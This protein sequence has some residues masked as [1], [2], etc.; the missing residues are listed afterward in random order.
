LRQ[1]ITTAL[2]N[3]IKDYPGGY[4]IFKELIQNSDDSKATEMHFV[5]DYVSLILL[6]SHKLLVRNL[7][8]EK[9]CRFERKLFFTNLF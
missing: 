1:D 5:I 7:F 3:N 9:Y 4:Q 8:D 6:L 2:K